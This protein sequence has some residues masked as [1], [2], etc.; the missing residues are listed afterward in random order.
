[1]ATKGPLRRRLNSW[2]WRATSSFPT[3][4]SPSSNTAKSVIDTRSID[5]RS[6][7]MIGV[8]PINGAAPSRRTLVGAHSPARASCSLDRSISR[9]SAPMCA[10]VPSI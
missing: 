9:T 2:I 10:A 6:A 1:M 7:A 8:D 5:P 3:P 4:L